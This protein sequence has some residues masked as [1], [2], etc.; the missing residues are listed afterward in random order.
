MRR[1]EQAVATIPRR[2]QGVGQP[3]HGEVGDRHLPTTGYGVA[4]NLTPEL[5][6]KIKDAFFSFPWEEPKLQE[7]FSKCGEAKFVPITFKENWAV[8]RQIDDA[9]GI[10][11]SCE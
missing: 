8:I 5:Q 3:G 9:S 4:H 7:E 10:E 1:V 6:E 11:Y 2:A